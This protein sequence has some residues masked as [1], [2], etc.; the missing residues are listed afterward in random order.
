MTLFCFVNKDRGDFGGPLDA[1][2]CRKES[3][4]LPGS[5]GKAALT[6]TPVGRRPRTK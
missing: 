5:G 2:A 1:R 3:L 4:E 6:G